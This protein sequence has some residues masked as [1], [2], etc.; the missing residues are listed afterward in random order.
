[1][2]VKFLSIYC[3]RLR[4]MVNLN[5]IPQVQILHIMLCILVRYIIIMCIVKQ[6]FLSVFFA[7]RHYHII[8]RHHVGD[9]VYYESSSKHFSDDN[10][11][12]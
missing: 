8:G 2:I 6:Y 7:K 9:C 11:F 10:I 12:P 4:Y 3:V 1:M 5:N